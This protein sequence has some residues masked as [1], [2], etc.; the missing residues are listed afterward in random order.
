MITTA[1]PVIRSPLAVL[2]ALCATIL[3][4]ALT[5]APPSAMRTVAEDK[6]VGIG[7]VSSDPTPFTRGKYGERAE[8]EANA[9]MCATQIRFNSGP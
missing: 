8:H 4:M 6:C 7:T 9:Q 3:I 1:S 5:V 2:P